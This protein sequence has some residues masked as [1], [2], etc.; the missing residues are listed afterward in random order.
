MWWRRRKR[1]D[2]A[3]VDALAEELRGFGDRDDALARAKQLLDEHGDDPRV[4]VLLGECMSM[5]TDIDDLN[6]APPDDPWFAALVARLETLSTER[7][8][9]DRER[10]ERL[11]ALAAA[12]RRL[13]RAG[14]ACAERAHAAEL[15]LRPERWQAH[16]NQ[17]LFWKT[18]GRFVHGQRANQRAAD[19]G[20]AHDQAVRW[21]LGICATG[22]GDG[23]TALRIWKQL[24]QKLEL[25]RFDLPDGRYPVAKVRLAERP[26]AERGGP[27][28]P[29]DPGYQENVWVERLSPC[30]GII[31]VALL[32]DE[33]GLEFGDVVMFDG[34]PVGYQRGPGGE[35]LPIYPHL[36]TLRRR[37]FQVHAFAGVQR[38]ARQLDALTAALPDECVVYPHTEQIEYLC[39]E[40]ARGRSGVPHQ[41]RPEQTH[42]VVRGKIC[43]PPDLLAAELRARLD[44]A[45]ASVDGARLYAPTLSAAAGDANRAAA[46]QRELELLDATTSPGTS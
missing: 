11:D 15:A 37:A 28:R 8:L 34:A 42:H 39:E 26:L 5:L 45:L 17:G 7:G 38:A 13:G 2:E 4:V 21:N 10:A 44:H 6:A 12:A 30:H 29:D 20:G 31:R 46:E 25:G 40:C 18:R 24:G 22:A 23:P 14:D 33:I 9:D 1:L 3:A 32:R 16:Y 35:R 19:L 36:A 43:A 41:H 27:D